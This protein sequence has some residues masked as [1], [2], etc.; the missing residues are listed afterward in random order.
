MRAASADQPCWSVDLPLFS[1]RTA[2]SRPG[3]SLA[4]ALWSS[5]LVIQASGC[6]RSLLPSSPANVRTVVSLG[7]MTP[8]LPMLWK[9]LIGC[10]LFAK[11]SI[12]AA[13][14]ASERSLE[15]WLLG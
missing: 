14:A 10:P 13:C 11:R 15:E 7:S 12:S 6:G 5:M 8:G 2:L 9:A 1:R 4:N 3:R